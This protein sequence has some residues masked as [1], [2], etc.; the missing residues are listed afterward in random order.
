MSGMPLKGQVLPS[1]SK[2]WGGVGWGGGWGGEQRELSACQW[3]L[4]SFRGLGALG[5]SC[6]PPRGTAP[7]LRASPP[8][9][10][11]SFLAACQNLLGDLKRCPQGYPRP[12]DPAFSGRGR[13]GFV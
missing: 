5:A 11:F 4:Y 10:G 8:G 7:G 9:Q 13:F 1:P 2:G 12:G 6:D 3:S